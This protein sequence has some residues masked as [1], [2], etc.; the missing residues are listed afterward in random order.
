MIQS[1]LARGFSSASETMTGS[2]IVTLSN[3][4]LPL[5]LVTKSNEPLISIN[6]LKIMNPSCILLDLGFIFASLSPG[7]V[8]RARSAGLQPGKDE[9]R[10]PAADKPD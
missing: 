8:G 10:L 9:L 1:D 7:R 6:K 4:S 2:T 5:I 3:D